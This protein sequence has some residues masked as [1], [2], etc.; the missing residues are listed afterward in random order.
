MNHQGERRK[1]VETR[2]SVDLTFGV[3]K[4]KINLPHT[5]PYPLLMVTHWFENE[6]NSNCFCRTL[7][8]SFLI[9]ESLLKNILQPKVM[10]LNFTVFSYITA[11]VLFIGFICGP[12]KYSIK[13]SFLFILSVSDS[14]G[15]AIW[16]LKCTFRYSIGNSFRSGLKEEFAW[17]A[18][19]E[20][21]KA[22]NRL[23]NYPNTGKWC[24]SLL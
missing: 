6:I 21:W 1:K 2:F 8:Q 19:L 23:F 18:Y 5:V 7:F 16:M 3:Y 14:G 10:S 20:M 4:L 24:G 13:R 11:N 22:I 17:N 12:Q 15:V 9:P